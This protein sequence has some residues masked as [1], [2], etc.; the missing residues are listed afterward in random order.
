MHCVDG[1]D[2]SAFSIL[3]PYN[4]LH[5]QVVTAAGKLLK[6]PSGIRVTYHAVADPEGSF[7]S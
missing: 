3:P 2:Y 7:N 6:S 1:N 5:V 4:N